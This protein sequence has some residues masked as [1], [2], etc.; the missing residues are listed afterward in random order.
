MSD[1]ICKCFIRF[2]VTEAETI[3]T[4]LHLFL[5]D[6]LLDIIVTVYHQIKSRIRTLFAFVSSA[7]D[8]VLQPII[9]MC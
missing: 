2:I 4:A 8:S 7:V 5:F 3:C 6:F 9:V 1:D